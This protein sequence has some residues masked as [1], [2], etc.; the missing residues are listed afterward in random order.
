MNQHTYCPSCKARSDQAHYSYCQREVWRSRETAP[1][2]G[3]PFLA[4]VPC[5]PLDKEQGCQDDG[6]MRVLWWETRGQFTSDRDT[7]AEDF[8]V[9]TPLPPQPAG[10]PL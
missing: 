10:A 1:K 5:T 7:G 3:T 2:D 4:W 6:D 9:W 8:D